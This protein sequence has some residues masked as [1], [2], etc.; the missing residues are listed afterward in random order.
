MVFYKPGGGSKEITLK[1]G[2][3]VIG[4]H[5]SATL[6]LPF[7]SI[8]REHCELVVIEDQVKLKDLGSSNGTFHNG[9]RI[10]ETVLSAGDYLHVG[11]IAMAIRV[12]GQ[13][14]P[15]APPPE[16]PKPGPAESSMMKTPPSG[17][18]AVAPAPASEPDESDAEIEEDVGE[19]ESMLSA[20]APDESS[21]IDLDIDLDDTDA[22]QL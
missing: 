17:V 19:D 2:R 16:M 4:R 11:E 15:L 10:T 14:E 20:L 13:P 21:M 12:N 9:S 8:S 1:Q 7:P 5:E 22:P 6:R 3:Y 18:K